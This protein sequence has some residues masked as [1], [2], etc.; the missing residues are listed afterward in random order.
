MGQIFE[1]GGPFGPPVNMLAETLRHRHRK[2]GLCRAGVPELSQFHAV[3]ALQPQHTTEVKVT[4]RRRRV[5]CSRAP[6]VRRKVPPNFRLRSA[7]VPPTFHQSSAKV[8]PTF[9]Q[10]SSYGTKLKRRVTRFVHS[11]HNQTRT[12]SVRLAQTDT[13][14]TPSGSVALFEPALQT[15]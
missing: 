15:D 12:C 2:N 5:G 8:P 13:F 6:S 10:G 7:K 11:S 3:L 9:R 14:I 4:I 1:A